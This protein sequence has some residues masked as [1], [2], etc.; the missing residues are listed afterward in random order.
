MSTF[1]TRLAAAGALAAMSVA[2]ERRALAE[3]GEAAGFF[4]AGSWIAVSPVRR[5]RQ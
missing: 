4:F 2:L 5:C 3:A 1:A